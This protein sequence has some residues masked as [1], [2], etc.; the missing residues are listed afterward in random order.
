MLS[1]TRQRTDLAQYEKHSIYESQ[2]IHGNTTPKKLVWKERE[3][4]AEAE[5]VSGSPGSNIHYLATSGD[6]RQVDI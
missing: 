5:P 4:A 6:V 2:S 3:K 1:E